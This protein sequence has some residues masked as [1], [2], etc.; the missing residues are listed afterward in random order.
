MLII[1]ALGFIYKMLPEKGKKLKNWEFAL[2]GISLFVAVLMLSSHFG[3]LAVGSLPLALGDNFTGIEFN[4]IT[5]IQSFI[6]IV[7]IFMY[8]KKK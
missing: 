7:L 2:I 4:T 3:F 8:I 5:L 6:I 1:V